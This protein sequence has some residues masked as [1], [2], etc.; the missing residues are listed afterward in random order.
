VVGKLLKDILEIFAN[1]AAIITAVVATWAYGRFWLGQR[2]RQ[3]K[4]EIYL[5]EQ[6][7]YGPD[8]GRRSVIHLMAYLSMTES[9]VQQAAFQSNVIVT[10]PDIDFQRQDVGLLFEYNGSYLPQPE[11]F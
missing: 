9:E 5:R 6:K 3:K 1:L 2:N 11:K 4:L 7:L 8:E 10:A